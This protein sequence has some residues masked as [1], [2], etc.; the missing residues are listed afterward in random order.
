MCWQIFSHAM[1][2]R[3]MH[4]LRL[5]YTD[6]RDAIRH[7]ALTSRHEGT[8]PRFY[9]Q[10]RVDKMLLTFDTLLKYVCAP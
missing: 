5:L 10:G 2:V 7:H 1:K 6:I 4:T 3:A 9:E 8:K